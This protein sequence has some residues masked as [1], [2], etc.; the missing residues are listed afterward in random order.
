MFDVI[1]GPTIQRSAQSV[2]RSRQFGQR[3]LGHKLRNEQQVVQAL[4]DSKERLFFAEQ[5]QIG[6]WKFLEQRILGGINVAMNVQIF[7]DGTWTN[8][9]VHTYPFDGTLLFCPGPLLSRPDCWDYK[10]IVSDGRI[11]R[12]NYAAVLEER[13]LPLFLYVQ[14]TASEP[15]LVCLPGLGCGMFAGSFKGMI[16]H[17]FI[18]TV[19]DI[20]QRHR[21][22]LTNIAMVYHYAYGPYQSELRY[23]EQISDTLRFVQWRNGPSMLSRPSVIDSAFEDDTPLYKFVAWDHFSWPG[24]DFFANSRQTDD[25]VSAAAT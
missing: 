21:D 19:Q 9:S 18:Q 8:P 13:I 14:E 20:L 2:L 22:R 6:G 4:L 1:Y 24:N 11:D 17:L 5:G 23:E 15:A 12:G 10:F 25:G 3:I 7:D 16:D